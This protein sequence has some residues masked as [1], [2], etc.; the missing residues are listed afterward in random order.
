MV[1]MHSV[2]LSQ[3]PVKFLKDVVFLEVTWK[4]YFDHKLRAT[5]LR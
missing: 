2:K 1:E 3:L 5:H 4:P